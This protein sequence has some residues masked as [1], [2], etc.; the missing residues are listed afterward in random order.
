MNYNYQKSSDKVWTDESGTEIPYNRTTK[1]E[2]LHERSSN[3]II[4]AALDVNKRLHSLNHLLT[5]LSQEAYDAY[6]NSKGVSK[7]AKGNYTWYNF[8]RSVKIEV[9]VSEPIVF[10]SLTITAAKEKLDEFLDANIESKNTFI[11]QMIIDAF[12]TQRSGSLDTKQVLKL[13]SYEDKVKSPKFSE[14]IKLIR[15]AIRRPKSKTYR[16]VWIK[17]EAGKYQNVELNLSSL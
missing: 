2:R 14:A 13:T 11:K 8:D 3:K 16:R 10:D 12:E 4:K 5:N 7:K 15:E 6:M 1:V 17:D 9:N